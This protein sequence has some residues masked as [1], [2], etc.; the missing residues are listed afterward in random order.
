M[1]EGNREKKGEAGMR[2][3]KRSIKLYG[4]GR[5]SDVILLRTRLRSGIIL[6]EEEVLVLVLGGEF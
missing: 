3:W 6:A 5:F 2:M 4:K 1:T